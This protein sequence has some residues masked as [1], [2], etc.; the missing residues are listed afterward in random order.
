M[1]LGHRIKQHRA[2]LGISQEVLAERIFVSRQTISNWET[3]RT[4]PDVQSLLLMAQLFGTT[5][6]DLVQGDVE[7]MEKQVRNDWDE[8]ERLVTIAWAM[9]IAGCAAVMAGSA[10]W[11][12]DS[13]I[14]PALT[15]GLVAGLALMLPLFIGGMVL[16]HRVEAIKKRNDLVTYRDI[17][18]Y[19]KGEEPVR[20]E[21]AFSRRH[22][23]LSKIALFFACAAAGG[24]LSWLA[25]SALMG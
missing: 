3:D 19:S 13:S 4:Y 6:D 20:D 5:L 12:Q 2:Q 7:I 14:I 23:A 24:I 25:M 17:L 8:I 21:A 1:E 16:L 10:L 15:E 18:A 9:I 11:R 22:P